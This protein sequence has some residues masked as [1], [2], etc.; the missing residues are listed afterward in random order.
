MQ[1]PDSPQLLVFSGATPE[2]LKQLIQNYKEFLEKTPEC[3]GDLAYTLSNRREH[4]SY[5]AFAVANKHDTVTVSP[6]AR[7]G[8]VPKVVMVFT[9]QGAQWP[10]MGRELLE[11]P[12]YTIFQ[13]S[14]K[15]LDKYLQASTFKPEWSI[16]EELLKGPKTSRLNTAEFSQPLC[17]AIQISLVNTLASIGVIPAAVVG[18]SSGEIAGAYA[19]GAITAKEAIT[20]AFH[21]GAATKLQTKAGA[22]AAIGLGRD[23]VE[24]FLMSGVIIACENSPKSVTLSGDA[25]KVKA[26]VASIKDA[27]PDI[28][29]RLLKVDK[30]YHSH[31]MVEIGNDYHKL[32][33]EEISEKEPTKLFFSSVTGQIYSQGTTRLSARYWQKNLESPVLFSTAVTTLL[34][35]EIAK[36]AVFLEIGPH[37]GLAGPLR[38]IQTQNSNSAP[39]IS[40]M[41]RNQDCVESFLLAIGKLYSVN[42]TVNFKKLVPS[43]TTLPDLPTYPWNHSETYWYES[44]LS[45]EWRH[46]EHPY[47]DLLGVRIPESIEFEPVWRNLFHLENAPWVRDHKVKHDVVFPFAGYAG[48]IGEAVRQVSGIQEAFT[49][50]HVVV[51]TA[52][53]LSEAKPT[54]IMTSFRRRRLTDYLDSEWWEFTISS[55]NGHMWSKHC[56]GQVRAQ[57]ESLGPGELRALPPRKVASKRCYDSMERSGLNF[58]PTFRRLEEIRSE[59]TRQV[60][61][62]MAVNKEEDQVGYQLHPTLIDASMQLLS[63][64]ATKGY[65]GQVHSKMLVPTHIEELSVH[66]CSTNLEITT[67][68]TFTLGGGIVGETKCTA[69][70][71]VVLEISGLRLTAVDEGGED[72]NTDTTARP[73]WGPHID[74]VDPKS[75]IKQSVDLSLTTSLLDEL[76]QSCM[77]SSQRSLVGLKSD[78]PHMQ[79]YASWMSRQLK[80][81]AQSELTN[82]DD[83]ALENLVSSLVERLSKTPAADAALAIYNT[84]IHIRGI[85]T[86]TKDALELLL[87]D[88]RLARIYKFADQCDRSPLL[89]RMSH[90]KPNLRV[91]EIGA[92]TGATTKSI[93]KDLAPAGGHILYSQYVYTDISTGMFVAATENFKDYPNIEYATLDISKDLADQGF[94]GRE[95]DLIVASNVIHATKSLQD[96]L[97]NV[98][99]LL[100]PNGRFFLTELNS[101]SKWVNYIW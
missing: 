86:G 61:T 24:K 78:I 9:G 85:F 62:A 77:I 83:A 15:S 55:H 76:T 79:K 16:E 50:R 80:T 29:A 3:I 17:T 87:D 35:H 73:E 10:Q 63:V 13:Q 31:H 93:L 84:F 4:L 66:R 89:K 12:S 72:E 34:K 56:T 40:T 45:K 43:G 58:G 90:S 28:L 52:L 33:A 74:F 68:A 60:A 14:I 38:Q 82:L 97:K 11:D 99:K 100:A 54:E 26:V 22:M 25:E 6:V 20:L 19:S 39:Y 41:L 69:A 5:R 88:D 21:R 18:H 44:R 53:V 98:R 1:A 91:L 57:A 32:I 65:A 71:H 101:T 23:E 2:S 8:Q 95:F 49:L 92:G 27:K 64:A 42:V 51:S 46:R 48:M 30:A 67:S 70:G 94:E 59:T 96:S 75:L 36:N 37:S 47:H 7:S 81:I